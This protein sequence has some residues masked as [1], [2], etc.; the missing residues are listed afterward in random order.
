[1]NLEQAMA[2]HRARSIRRRCPRKTKAPQSEFGFAQDCFQ[3]VGETQPA[4]DPP[5]VEPERAQELFAEMR[6][7]LSQVRC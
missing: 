2:E 6:V 3:L 1:M 7:K 5:R 4:P